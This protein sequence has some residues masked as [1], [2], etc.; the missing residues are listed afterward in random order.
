MFT[1][2]QSQ[3]LVTIS[4]PNQ[5]SSNCNSGFDY[6]GDS[7]FLR[8]KITPEQIRLCAPKNLKNTGSNP[9]CYVLEFIRNAAEFMMETLKETSFGTARRVAEVMVS[10]YP[11][12]F[13]FVTWA[14]DNIPLRSSGVKSLQKRIY[15]HVRRY[16]DAEKKSKR[17]RVCSEDSDEESNP[18]SA[19]H[20]NPAIVIT[21]YGKN[22][23]SYGCVAYEPLLSE[24]VSK[25]SQLANKNTLLLSLTKPELHLSFEEETRLLN[26]TYSTQRLCLNRREKNDLLLQDIIKDHWPHLKQEQHFLTHASTLIGKDVA[27]E[28]NSNLNSKGSSI[29]EYFRDYNRKYMGHKNIPDTA[30]RVKSKLSEIKK[31][32]KE[33]TCEFPKMLGIIPLITSFF[34]EEDLFTLVVSINK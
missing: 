13:E 24:G 19:P 4:T 34:N 6:S 20:S 26:I 31:T 32:C 14:D 9:I 28:W 3:H 1:G 15:D 21:R 30:K 22:Q 2:S 16:K 10:L 7:S 8:E 27:A 29:F 17:K 11:A 25:E 12:V 33:L 18:N 23:D 5:G